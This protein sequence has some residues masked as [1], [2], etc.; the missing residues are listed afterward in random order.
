MKTYI[1]A[2]HL[3]IINHNFNRSQGLSFA[4]LSIV[5]LSHVVR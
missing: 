4:Q 2:M 5:F 3:K 1:P